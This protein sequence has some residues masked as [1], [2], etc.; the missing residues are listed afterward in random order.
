[1]RYLH[2]RFTGA[3]T[4]L[5][6]L[7]P[8]LTDETVFEQARMVDWAPSMD[9]P[10]STVLLYLVG[11][12]RA[13]ETVLDETDVVIEYDVTRFDDR[14]GYAY[15]HSKPHPTE[16]LL[17]DAITRGGLIPVCPIEYHHDG[18]LTIRVVGSTPRLQGMVA[19]IPDGVETSIER[20]GEYDLGRPPIPDSLPARQ[21]EALSVAYEL[22]YY[23]VPRTASRDDVAEAMNCAPSTA[24]EHLRKA[25]SRVVATFLNR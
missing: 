19:D 12:L 24:T 13:F 17:F 16:W 9:P 3:D 4:D 15:V 21:R 2:V 11:D 22:G 25:E 6:P 8:T 14:R 23:D 1:M 7:V 5:H 10:R 20:V 18:S